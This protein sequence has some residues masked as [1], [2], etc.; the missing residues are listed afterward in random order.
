MPADKN[1]VP[2]KWRKQGRIIK[3]CLYL[4]GD[5]Q[6]SRTPAPARQHDHGPRHPETWGISRTAEAVSTNHARADSGFLLS[7]RAW[8]PVGRG[9]GV[10]FRT[11]RKPEKAPMHY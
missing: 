9:S 10:F 1:G 3:F 6:P 7:A 8:Y 11:W 2:R 5:V 4:S